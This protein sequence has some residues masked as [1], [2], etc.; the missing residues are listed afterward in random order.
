M[1]RTHDKTAEELISLTGVSP[2]EALAAARSL[3]ATG[4]GPRDASIAHQAA[5]IVLRDFGDVRAAIRE[6]RLAA[7]LA[8]AAAEPD[9]EADVLTSLGT[10]LVMAG[11]TQAGLAALDEA[12]ALAASGTVRG[13]ILVR[14]GGSLYIAGRYDEARANLRK[15][16][17]LTR[18]SGEVLWEARAR[19][20]AALADL[21]VG[22]TAR[23]EAG[24]LAAESL[25]AGTGQ[26]LEIA[27]A[28]Q[29]R[30]LVAFASGDLP[31]ALRHL[32]DA[33]ARYAELGVAVPDAAL[34]RCAVL[35]AAGLPADALAGVEAALAG[36]VTAT[37]Q[38]EL[39]LAAARIALA[40]GRPGQAAER[41]KVARSMFAAQHRE[42][43]RTHATLVLLQAGFLRGVGG[44][45][46]PRASR[47]R[48]A[49]AGQAAG[50]GQAHR[51]P[52]GRVALGRGPGRLA[53]GRP[54]RAGGTAGAGR[55]SQ[56]AARLCCS[57]RAP[58]GAGLRPRR[59]LAGNGAAGGTGRGPA[60][61]AGCLRAGVRP[62]RGAPGH[63]GRGRAQGARHRARCR[64]RGA[65]A[66]DHAAFRPAA[67]AARMERALARGRPRRPGGDRGSRG[68]GRTRRTARRDGP[69]G[70]GRNPDPRKTR[71]LSRCR[72]APRASPAGGRHPPPDATLRAGPRRSEDRP[73]RRDRAAGPAGAS[74]FGPVA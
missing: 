40:A 61:V 36:R 30:A 22:A 28:R 65:R 4:P 48:R 38:A 14:R 74:G 24:F 26:Q 31:A 9:R 7:R 47:V 57:R 27:Y 17:T 19:T 66:A 43:W 46:P 49:A 3:L 73:V 2:R 37:K 13:R 8:R 18:R 68:P 62:A 70:A 72:A 60:A 44:V 1:T 16:I 32:D 69:P 63:A 21:A 45:A 25:F 34:D 42:W 15:A 53:A 10:A 5:A 64:A 51:G 35:L 67:P 41:A 59:G 29:N 6:F 20:A 12:L 11:R 56:P 50:R 54:D 58:P 71:R 33:A 52:A 39:R 23:A 55:G